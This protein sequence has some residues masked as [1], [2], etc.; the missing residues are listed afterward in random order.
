MAKKKAAKALAAKK[1]QEKREAREKA[2]A[3]NVRVISTR[4][5]RES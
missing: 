4:S 5:A 3:S 2:K 1:N